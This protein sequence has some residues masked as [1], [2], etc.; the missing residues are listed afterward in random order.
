MQQRDQSWVRD[1]IDSSMRVLSYVEDRDFAGF[2]AS[3]MTQ[4]AVLYRLMVIGEA[5]KRLT[6]ETRAAA[7]E[8]DWQ[9]VAGF[10]DVA[11]HN[12]RDVRLT[13]VWEI[14]SEE[15]PPFLERLQGLLDAGA[16]GD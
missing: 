13:R 2:S 12:P 7:P 4:D 16:P 11:I 5:V 10:R 8:I 1:V 3:G 14:V 9:G 6:P 15:L